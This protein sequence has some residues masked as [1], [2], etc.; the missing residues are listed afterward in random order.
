MSRNA[1]LPHGRGFTLIEVLLALAIFGILSVLAYRATAAMSDS[2]ARLTQEAARW[3]ALEGFFARFEADI[4]AAVPRQARLGSAT[5]PAWLATIDATGQAALVI[6]RAA[7]EFDG[8]PARAGERIGYRLREGAIEIAYWPHLD[9]PAGTSPAV[10]PLVENIAQWRLEYLTDS[11]AWRER[12]P[13]L[14]EPAIPRAVRVGLTLGTGE[15]IERAF[16]LR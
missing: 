4:R 13:W 7:A 8:E 3:H 5:E 6:T 10:Y 9:N 1:G 12:W 14:S 11:G 15:T 2:E 16:A